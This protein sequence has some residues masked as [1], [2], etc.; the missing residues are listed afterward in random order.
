MRKALLTTGIIAAAFIAPSTMAV[1]ED[2]PFVALHVVAAAGTVDQQAAAQKTLGK[3]AAA[4]KAEADKRA[5][6]RKSARDAAA[7]V[8]KDERASRAKAAA[9][10]Y[11]NNLD[12]WIDECVA[13]TGVPNWWKPKLKVGALRESGGR[14]NANNNWDSNA[15]QGQD[16]QSKGLFQTIGPTFRS[17]HEPGTSWEILD[18]VANCAAAVNYIQHRYGSINNV[19]QFNIN[20]PPKGY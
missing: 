7:K 18:P 16:M 17:N 14:P 15:A 9:P 3:A 19:Q 1:A 2:N 20:L 11:A 12:G 13:K 6:E 4:K 8:R 10:R 5:A